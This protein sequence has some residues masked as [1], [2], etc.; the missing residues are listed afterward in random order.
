MKKKTEKEEKLKKLSVWGA[1]KV[2]GPWAL[3]YKAGPAVTWKQVQHYR[4]VHCREY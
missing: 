3:R 1:A 2:V 4:L